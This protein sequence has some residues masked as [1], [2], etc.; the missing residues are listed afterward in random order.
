MKYTI[1]ICDV[2][3][4]G[5]TREIKHITIQCTFSYAEQVARAILFRFPFPLV[6]I[7]TGKEE[8]NEIVQTIHKG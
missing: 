4:N 7:E 8:S 3:R 6:R 5:S 1:I 2:L